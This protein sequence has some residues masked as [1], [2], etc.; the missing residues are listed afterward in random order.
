[1]TASYTSNH[2]RILLELGRRAK[3]EVNLRRAEFFVGLCFY[4]F[5]EVL[6]IAH[7]ATFLM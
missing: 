5:N 2:D 4:S 1:M 3:R 6:S 7:T